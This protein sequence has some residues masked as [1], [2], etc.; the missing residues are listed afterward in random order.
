MTSDILFF[1]ESDVSMRIV[2]QESAPSVVTV[3]AQINNLAELKRW[4]AWL[5]LQH[6]NNVTFKEC[7]LF[8]RQGAQDVIDRLYPGCETTPADGF[9]FA[10]RFNCDSLS[11][12]ERFLNN[13]AELRKNILGGPMDRAFNALLAR[14]AATLPPAVVEYRAGEPV[15]VVENGGKI[16]VIFAVEFTDDTDKALAKVFLQEFEEVQR[17]FVRN[18]PPALYSPVGTPPGELSRFSYNFKSSLVGFLSFSVEERHIAGPG[19]DNAI[20]LLTN[21]R[22]YLHYHIKSSKTYLHMRM[23]KKVAGWMLVLNR[24]MP[25]VETEKKTITGKSFVRK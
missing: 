21:F 18:A 23:R 17:M 25:E 2:V 4:G 14:Q 5:A 9:N 7:L 1:F 10:I 15:F 24:A 8:N 19:K 11:D 16:I 3:H 20:A 13:V 12:P 6:L 22:N